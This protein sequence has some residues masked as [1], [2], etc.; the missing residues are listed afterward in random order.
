MG[1]LEDIKTLLETTLSSLT[2]SITLHQSLIL[3]LQRENQ[4]LKQQ[5]SHV[6]SKERI[7]KDPLQAEVITKFKR[8]KRRLIKNK[9]LETVKQKELSIPE[10]KEIVVDQYKY[11]SKASFYRYI[12]ELK[13]HDFILVTGENMVRIKPLVE[14][15]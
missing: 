15:V 5:L 13:Q 14:V 11:C 9:I 2:S 7:P 12:E 1:D 10:I 4:E 6:I 8:N 3:Q